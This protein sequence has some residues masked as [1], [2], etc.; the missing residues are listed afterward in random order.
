[1]QYRFM[2]EHSGES[3]NAK[4]REQFEV[5]ALNAVVQVAK[6]D[7][8]VAAELFGTSV[9]TLLARLEKHGLLPLL[10]NA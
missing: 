8:R 2:G 10:G 3:L 5:W 6:E 9:E 4:I 1:M 7:L